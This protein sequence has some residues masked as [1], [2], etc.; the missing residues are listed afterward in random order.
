MLEDMQVRDLAPNTQE[1]YVHQVSR[2]ARHFHRSPERLG[3]EEILTYE[4]HPT[5]A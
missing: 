3:P 4:I 1:S 2:F 5:M